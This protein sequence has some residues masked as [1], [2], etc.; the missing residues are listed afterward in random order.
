MDK[1]AGQM[2]SGESEVGKLMKRNTLRCGIWTMWWLV[3]LALAVF[4]PTFLWGDRGG[5]TVVVIVANV[6]FG[7]MAIRAHK[8]WLGGLD[9]LQRR[10][11]LE[12]LAL[13]YGVGIVLGMAYSCLDISNLIQG[14]AEIG[15]QVMIMGLS[16]MGGLGYGNWRYR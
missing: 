4:G 10:I 16:Y 1:Q 6:I 7:V 9:E 2:N 14:D 15:I 5:I 3:S 13:A 11:Q 8:I 12:A